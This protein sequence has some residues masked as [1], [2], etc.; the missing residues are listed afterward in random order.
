MKY[1]LTLADVQAL[2]RVKGHA[3]SE[4]KVS[5]GKVCKTLRSNFVPQISVLRTKMVIAV[6]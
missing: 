3:K 6:K 1:A 2:Y 4:S 5:F